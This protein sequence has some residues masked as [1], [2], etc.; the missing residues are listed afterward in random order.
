MMIN[1]DLRQNGG[2]NKT[3]PDVSKLTPEKKRNSQVTKLGPAESSEATHRLTDYKWKFQTS[4]QK[5]KEHCQNFEYGS[6]SSNGILQM[7]I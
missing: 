3:R 5:S 7:F 1:C 6:S 4:V 2:S